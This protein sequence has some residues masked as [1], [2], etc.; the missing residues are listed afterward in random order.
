MHAMLLSYLLVLSV[1]SIVF[2]L[3]H[4]SVIISN[5][6]VDYIDQAVVQCELVCVCILKKVAA[7]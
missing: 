6:V 1:R 2:P 5:N 3:L 7:S 4:A